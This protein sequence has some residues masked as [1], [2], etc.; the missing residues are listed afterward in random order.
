VPY[1]AVIDFSG[2]EK[3]VDQVGG[4]DVQVDRTFTDSTYPDSGFGYLAPITFQQGQQHFNGV[5]ALQFARSR[6][7]NNNEGSD[8]ARSLRQQKIIQAFKDKV[9]S[10]NIIK[11]ASTLNSLLEVFAD[12][13]HTNM[14]PRELLRVYNLLEGRDVQIFSSSLDPE[15]G[16]IC[17]LILASTGA[18]VLTPCQGRSEE[19]VANFFKNSF[20]IGKI[21]G[22]KSIIW[23]ADSTGNAQRYNTAFRKLTN[24][25][26]IVY[27]LSYT[28]DNL[29]QTIVY[30]ANPKPATAE[31]I[32]NTLNGSDV[33]LPP[34]DMTVS[35]DRVDII[36]VLGL[37]APIEAAP[38]PYIR[39]PEK[40]NTT[41]PE[42]ATTTNKSV[43]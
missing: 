16:I 13:F 5:K 2:F 33:N 29:P 9:L 18:Y 36:V 39:P 14:T 17:P 6:H 24:A 20:S 25:G 15:T 21:G 40:I 26:L 19:D 34:P 38:A 4:L 31:F 10:L 3:A 37:N 8:F 32:R 35:K 41:T 1:F 43:K 30:Q 11:S 27:Q 22:E 23:L 12:H 7:G 42:T 28:K